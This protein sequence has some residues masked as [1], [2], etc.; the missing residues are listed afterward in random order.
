MIS[1]ALVTTAN[2]SGGCLDTPIASR[3]LSQPSI[4]NTAPPMTASCINVRTRLSLHIRYSRALSPW[5]GPMLG[6][7]QGIVQERT[8]PEGDRAVCDVEHIPIVGPPVKVKKVG[9]PAVDQ[10]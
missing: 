5:R 1:G 8:H 10:P 6:P 3:R 2:S 9:N 7:Q 4:D